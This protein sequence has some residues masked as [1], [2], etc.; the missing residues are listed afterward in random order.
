MGLETFPT[1]HISA[2][3]RAVPMT[4]GTRTVSVGVLPTAVPRPSSSGSG[5]RGALHDLG[6]GLEER[7]EVLDLGGARPQPARVQSDPDHR[8]AE[9]DRTDAQ[10]GNDFRAAVAWDRDPSLET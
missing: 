2:S 5:H 8:S 1:W 9:I 4:R 6:P 10:R 7:P 3:I